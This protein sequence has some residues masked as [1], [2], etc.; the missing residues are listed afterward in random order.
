M[1]K[2]SCVH[3]VK[4][5]KKH[6]I[7]LLEHFIINYMVYQQSKWFSVR[8]PSI[9]F[10]VISQATLMCLFFAKKTKLAICKIENKCNYHYILQN[11][12]QSIIILINFSQHIHLITSCKRGHLNRFIGLP[13]RLNCYYHSPP[14]FN[15]AVELIT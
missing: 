5:C 8:L 2:H 6:K 12:K 9:L 13:A 14:I 10:L 15:S 3:L 7:F 11:H 1:V 4:I